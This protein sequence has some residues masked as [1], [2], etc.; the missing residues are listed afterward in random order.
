MKMMMPGN[1]LS[2]IIDDA[3]HRDCSVLESMFSRLMFTCNK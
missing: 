2:Y 1:Q 3:F